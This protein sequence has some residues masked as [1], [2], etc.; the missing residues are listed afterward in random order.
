MA[1]SFRFP[2]RSAVQL[3]VKLVFC[4]SLAATTAA[5]TTNAFVDDAINELGFE[6]AQ[7]VDL[8]SGKII[9]VGLP[10]IELQPTELAVGAAMMLVRRPLA[11]VSDM[12]MSEDTF[13]VNQK[14]LDFGA[15]GDGSANREELHAIFDKIEYSGAERSEA[16]LLLEAKPG[17]QFNLSQEE[18]EKFSSLQ[19]VDG[20]TY[21]MVSSTLANMLQKRFLDYT[22]G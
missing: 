5:D 14:I 7:K 6:S 2:M 15:I 11:A 13:R 16:V 8:E 4:S 21:N 19:S 17:K 1:K 22:D 9:S 3:L 18:I 12:L 20:L 10:D